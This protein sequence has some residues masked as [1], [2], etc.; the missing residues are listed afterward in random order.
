MNNTEEQFNG[1][2][3]SAFGAP[4]FAY[5]RRV[6]LDA[7]LPDLIN[8]PTGAGK[9]AAVLGAWLWRRL[10]HPESVGRR[11][12]YCLPMRTLV[13]QTARVACEAIAK[14][15]AENLLKDREI[16]VHVL[17]GGD[18][19]I[20][21]DMLPER[22]AVI[23][24]TQD[25][26]LSRALNRGYALAPARYPLHFG[27]LNNDCTWIFD[28]PQLMGD[29]LAT[30][31][32]LAAFRQQFK[33]FANSNSIWMSATLDRKWLREA[34]DFAAHVDGLSKLKLEEEDKQTPLLAKRLNAVKHLQPTS[35]ASCRLPEGLA[36][37][38]K[39][40]HVPDS[41]TLVVVNT[42]ARAR[43]VFAALNNEYAL[44]VKQA[45]NTKGASQQ[46]ELKLE[47]DA[48]E[49]RLIH[50]RFRPVDK[51]AWSDIFK[52]ALD[53][54]QVNRIVI[55]TQV[56][57]AGVD[58]SSRT[59]IT[60][61]APFAS[62]VQRFGRCNRQGEHN[63]TGAS[64]FWID[65]PLTEKTAKL[66]D[67]P[68]LDDKEQATVALPYKAEHVS[69]ARKLIEKRTSAA[70]ADLPT[71]S[72]EF[73]PEYVL[74]RRDIIDLFD[75]T[76][77]LS[78]YDLDISRF[79]RGGDER[80][81]YVAWRNFKDGE[82]N[83]DTPRPA[84][85][86]LCAVGIGELKKFLEDKQK[87]KMIDIAWRF[88]PLI[89]STSKRRKQDV[90]HWETVDAN[91]LRPGLTILLNGSVGGYTKE[92]GWTPDSTKEVVEV[93]LEE[94]ERQPEATNG[95]DEHSENARNRVVTEENQKLRPRY[96]QT[97]EAHTTEVYGRLIEILN[98]LANPQLEPH[99]KDL[100]HAALHHDWGKVHD[101]FQDTMRRGLG[102]AT[103]APDVPLAKTIGRARHTRK[104]F[105]HEL[106]SAL[107]LL[108]KGESD[109]C[110]Y[111]AACHHGKVR[112]SIRAL[113][114]ETKPPDEGKKYARG[115]HDGDELKPTRL[116][117]NTIT[118]SV[119][120]DLEP[121]LIGNSANGEASWLERMIRLRDDTEHLGI[122]RLA[123][124]ECLIRAADVQASA[125]PIDIIAETNIPDVTDTEKTS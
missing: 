95:D 72:D 91:A 14:L 34:V 23:I 48:P 77:D 46:S 79:V 124:L 65:R 76:T 50:S 73:A 117:E 5:Q 110:V 54:N 13:E 101:I 86:E 105:R 37:F 64:I 114:N 6:A 8:A 58:I 9:T 26:L 59:L 94:L 99:K 31:A 104:H 24:G 38:V 81:V 115:I 52:P 82:P 74:R 33:T 92:T 122:F 19:A 49:L 25:M 87:A 42:V 1:F 119:T 51:K 100:L 61:I 120:L 68:T 84:Q 35:P 29:A 98:R 43:E 112:L 12:V 11:L 111:L 121:M 32:Q 21:W 107:A 75:T 62:L 69:T 41:Q 10:H 30:T 102:E 116:N 2:F 108:Q 66:N 44:K 39:E 60:D 96:A 113:P 123:Y 125:N 16:A 53:G 106:A 88:N 80:D 71:H 7:K 103:P 40:K 28:E 36:A 20:D 67:K 22:E 27:L 47:P 55:A 89:E 15:E 93:D 97:L 83:D 118:E 90:N 17:M 63:D 109:L 3:L 45:K 57:E 56:V 85:R 18:V 78:G 70:P 4:P